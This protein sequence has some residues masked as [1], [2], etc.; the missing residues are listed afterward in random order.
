MPLFFRWEK[1]QLIASPSHPPPAPLCPCIWLSLTLSCDLTCCLVHSNFAAYYAPAVLTVAFWQFWSLAGERQMVARMMRWDTD[2]NSY[3]FWE[4]GVDQAHI[5]TFYHC[6]GI[7]TPHLGKLKPR[8][9]ECVRMVRD[10]AKT[11]WKEM[12]IWQ[13]FFSV[14]IIPYYLIMYNQLGF[15]GGNSGKEYAC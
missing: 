2:E 12:A 4:S 5:S 13:F 9:Y 8:W 3:D 6:R 14:S 7:S 1:G 15:L 11:G 10:W